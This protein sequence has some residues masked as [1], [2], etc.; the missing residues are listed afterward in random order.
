MVLQLMR[1]I[2]DA[3]CFN[4]TALLSPQVPYTPMP[5]LDQL[6]PFDGGDDDDDGLDKDLWIVVEKGSICNA[7]DC[8]YRDAVRSA[9]W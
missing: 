8:V 3:R 1:A 4:F 7:A 6:K 2:V 5:S 9:S